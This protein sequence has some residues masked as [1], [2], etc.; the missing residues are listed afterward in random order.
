[1][2]SNGSMLDI[3]TQSSSDD[4]PTASSSIDGDSN[5][6]P[7]DVK[8]IEKDGPVYNAIRRNGWFYRCTL[9]T[10]SCCGGPAMPGS[11]LVTTTPF[12]SPKQ[13]LVA[14]EMNLKPLESVFHATKEC[15]QSTMNRMRSE[16]ESQ[17]ESQSQ[18]QSR[19]RAHLTSPTTP[20][21][22]APVVF[23]STLPPVFNVS[24]G[25][26]GSSSFKTDPKDNTS[27]RNLIVFLSNNQGSGNTMEDDDCTQHSPDQVGSYTTEQKAS[28]R[29]SK[30][31]VRFGA[32][33]VLCSLPCFN[34]YCIERP[35]LLKEGVDLKS[36]RFR[37][38]LAK[39]NF[40]EASKGAE[41]YI[42]DT[43]LGLDVQTRDFEAWLARQPKIS[44]TSHGAQIAVTVSDHKD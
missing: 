1:M 22:L 25:T 2:W 33:T 27:Q 18:L 42:P 20:T 26:C 3:K 10:L 32:K 14:T 12:I 16:S 39:F 38:L 30:A 31:E 40:Y 9:P 44:S 41:K 5:G 15:F 35:E 19:S 21:V 28:G 34:T 36:K 11:G 23:E 17:L 4:K 8:S 37:I 24:C 29:G 6:P 43:T 13:T 7:F